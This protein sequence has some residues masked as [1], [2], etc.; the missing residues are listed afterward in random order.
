MH[1]KYNY[2]KDKR[3]DKKYKLDNYIGK[4]NQNVCIQEYLNY[5]YLV[6]GQKY[7]GEILEEELFGDTD[8]KIRAYMPDFRLHT[9]SGIYWIEVKVQMVPLSEDLHFK[10]NQ[11]DKLIDLNGYVLFSM[12]KVFFVHT[13]KYLKSKSIDLRISN[14]FHKLC[15]II[16]KNE[17]TWQNWLHL[18]EYKDYYR[19]NGKYTSK[20]K[21]ERQ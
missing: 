10:K 16:D 6:D 5:K 4:Y 9:P 8:E 21:G 11:L 7:E 19:E 20:Q 14:R 1:S 2:G 12:K 18:P 17:L 3:S 15:Y 13:A